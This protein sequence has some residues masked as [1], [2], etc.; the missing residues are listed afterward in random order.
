MRSF[1]ICIILIQ[2]CFNLYFMGCD[3]DRKKDISM[4]KLDML[5]AKDD[6]LSY[7]AEIQK[8]DQFLRSNLNG[9]FNAIET[10]FK[11]IEANK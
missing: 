7:I 9:I 8:K 2:S 6:Y 10:K 3:N 4:I 11:D 5:F 1:L